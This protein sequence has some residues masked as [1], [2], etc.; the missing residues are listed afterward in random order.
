MFLSRTSKY[1][2]RSLTRTSQF[3]F[4]T[5]KP[6]S[7]GHKEDKKQGQYK[8]EEVEKDIEEGRNGSDEE[9]KEKRGFRFYPFVYGVN[10]VLF[11]L[12]FA[13]LQEIDAKYD[14]LMGKALV[15]LNAEQ[16]GGSSDGTVSDRG[17]FSE[18]EKE[19]L[20]GVNEIY[21]GTIST[22]IYPKLCLFPIINPLAFWL[23]FRYHKRGGFWYCSMFTTIICALWTGI[24]SLWAIQSMAS[25]KAVNNKVQN[26]P[27]ELL[28]IIKRDKN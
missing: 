26:N 12:L 8:K 17:Y 3:S 4:C 2:L 21:Q 28:K 14:Q 7:E 20:G 15:E 6:V 25:F 22:Q 9:R 13:D 23:Q 5:Q 19:F 24:I 18:N 16:D 10:T 1:V 11:G 27:E